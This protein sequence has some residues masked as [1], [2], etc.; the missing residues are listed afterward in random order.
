M[1]WL[2]HV[3]GAFVP[4]PFSIGY[5]VLAQLGLALA[6]GLV[7]SR[8]PSPP[9][10]WLAWLFVVAQVVAVE[11]LTAGQP[12]G[13]RMLAIIGVALWSLKSVVSVEALLAG[14]DPL[15]WWRWLL[16]AAAWPGMRPSAFAGPLAP[17][18]RAATGLAVR[19]IVCS[20]VGAACLV[21]SRLAA[22]STIP[23]A[24]VVATAVGLVGISL[25]LHFG[26]FNLGAATWR[27]VG[28]STDRLFL[29]PLA[30]TSLAEFWGKRWNL[31]FTEM[32]QIA[33]Y[34]PISARWNK[35]AGAALGFLYSGLLHEMA[36]SLPTGRGFGLPLL[37][38]AIHGGL[39]LLER[40]WYRRGTPIAGRPG[41][42]HVWT[43]GWLALPMPILFHPPFLEG[44]VWP[45][46]GI[47]AP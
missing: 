36:I 5:V 41:L 14:D 28:F 16:F 15:P 43:L 25:L 35:Q 45:L 3:A 7:S 42:R 32:T 20:V 29:A 9:W 30:S 31:A 37:Y 26:A 44:V 34:R 21:L 6:V 40:R 22:G 17:D 10:R 12:D 13:F 33:I 19:G 47:A 2:D 39:V 38:F 4:A 24:I 23:S 1:S 11:R 46:L 18:P 27:L 8:R